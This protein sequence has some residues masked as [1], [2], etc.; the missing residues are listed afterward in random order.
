MVSDF[1]HLSHLCSLCGGS[2]FTN[3]IKTDVNRA[4][5][6]DL[7]RRS[8][9]LINLASR[10]D[11]T[12][13]GVSSSTPGPGPRSSQA[14]RSPALVTVK[15]GIYH[16]FIIRH[17]RINSFHRAFCRVS[18]CALG[19]YL[20]ELINQD[21]SSYRRGIVYPKLLRCSFGICSTSCP[22]QFSW[23]RRGVF[24][25]IS[26]SAFN[27]GTVSRLIYWYYQSLFFLSRT[28]CDYQIRHQALQTPPPGLD[29]WR[30]QS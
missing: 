30:K 5:I 11:R 13:Q 7:S 26:P 17:I 15:D 4:G 18:S 21:H 22:N 2:L 24:A 29:P 6:P 10:L 20:Y 28:F 25:H 1:W 16:T 19:T 14:P 3:A 23:S 12:A 27:L 8:T 9:Q